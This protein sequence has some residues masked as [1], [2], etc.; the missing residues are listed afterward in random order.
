FLSLVDLYRFGG[1]CFSL[2]HH[3]APQSC[4]LDSDGAIT[5]ASRS[6]VCV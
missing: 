4:Y 2:G 1:N 3:F 6:G 5:F